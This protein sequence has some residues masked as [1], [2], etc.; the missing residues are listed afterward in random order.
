M[1]AAASWDIE[2]DTIYSEKRSTTRSPKNLDAIPKDYWHVSPKGWNASPKDWNALDSP[3]SISSAK[4]LSRATF[5]GMKLPPFSRKLKRTNSNNSLKSSETKN[6][7]SSKNMSNNRVAPKSPNP[8][9]KENLVAK[10]MRRATVIGSAATK[11]MSPKGI[12][13]KPP[14]RA[15]AQIM[16][17]SLQPPFRNDNPFQKKETTPDSQGREWQTDFTKTMTDSDEESNAVTKFERLWNKDGTLRSE[18]DDSEGAE[19]ET[20]STPV[21][22]P[23]PTPVVSRTESRDSGCQTVPMTDADKAILTKGLENEKFSRY[24]EQLYESELQIKAITDQVTS[25]EDELEVK[26]ENFLAVEEK[27]E[28][29][30]LE[31]EIQKSEA[32]KALKESKWQITELKSALEDRTTQI[33]T[34]QRQ[35]DAVYS[36]NN[37]EMRDAESTLKDLQGKIDAIQVSLDI[38]EVEVEKLKKKLEMV[39]QER[40]NRDGEEREEA[41]VQLADFREQVTAL[42]DALDEKE[43]EVIQ[44]QRKVDE[45]E[46]ENKVLMEELEELLKEKTAAENGVKVGGEADA[47]AKSRI[48]EL[49]NELEDATKVANLQLEE[50]DE[51]VDQLQDKLKAER[52]DSAAKIK[53]RDAT[54][55]ELTTKLRKYESVPSSSSHSFGFTNHSN[56]MKTSSNHTVDS[57]VSTE[58]AM[59]DVPSETPLICTDDVLDIE[60]AKQ[61]VYEARADATSVRESL[62]ISTKRCAELTLANEHLTQKNS[63]LV[64]TSRERDEL[65]DRVRD[66][67][68]QTYMWKRRAEE[69]ESKLAKLTDADDDDAIAAQGNMI[70]AVMEKGIGKKTEEKSAGGWNLWRKGDLKQNSNHKT[71]A[72]ENTSSSDGDLSAEAKEAQIETLNE[73][74]AKLRSEI[75]QINTAH[76]EETYLTKKRISELEGENEALTIQNGTLEQLSRFHQDD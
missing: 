75:F 24:D 56:G 17:Q 7:V 35:L 13:P 9:R 48:K 50:L 71:R 21:P 10:T 46:C 60:S 61:K 5:K 26:N 65:K 51:Q 43:S 55:D 63:E 23:T 37:E 72:K 12:S 32:D 4:S 62:E 42:Q 2:S 76:K 25:L 49:E 73:T 31:N 1:S 53:T 57:G 14:R 19:Y 64:D 47:D 59:I 11:V 52:M 22:T 54:I 6:S 33:E 34:L 39:E 16:Q 15:S 29:S 41:D 67:T 36:E 69:A 44:L 20:I 38:K 58:M 45:A 30:L 68:A 74:I 27:L 66:W 28:A 70:A 8:K 18:V 40:D 3:G